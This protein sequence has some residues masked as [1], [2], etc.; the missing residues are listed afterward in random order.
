MLT[1]DKTKAN[2][3]FLRSYKLAPPDAH[4]RGAAMIYLKKVGVMP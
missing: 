1:G 4:Y 2:D 3:F